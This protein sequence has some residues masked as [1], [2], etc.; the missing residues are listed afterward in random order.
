MKLLI[1]Y[2][3]LLPIIL[4]LGLSLLYPIY[5]WHKYNGWK[6]GLNKTWPRKVLEGYVIEKNNEGIFSELVGLRW[7]TCVSFFPIINIINVLILISVI[8]LR[9][10]K[11]VYEKCD[12][13]IEKLEDLLKL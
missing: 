3:W 12:D 13:G 11:K 9:N 4:I 10:I 5:L 2:Y 8:N 1:F 6:L 7:F